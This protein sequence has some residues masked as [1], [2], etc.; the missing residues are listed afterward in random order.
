VLTATRGSG[1]VVLLL[2]GCHN[3]GLQEEGHIPCLCH[4]GNKRRLMPFHKP[5]HG[6]QGVHKGR[7]HCR[8]R[9]VLPDQHKG[10]YPRMEERGPLMEA[11]ANTGILCEHNP[12][13]APHLLESRYITGVLG[14][15]VI[16]H[17]DL[18]PCLSEG[19]C[20]DVLSETAIEEKDEWVYAAWRLNSHRMASSMSRGERS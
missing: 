8:T 2:L 14:E 4:A 1:W 7:C 10:P 20:H 5:L 19:I 9:Q 3:L 13:T 16:M 6:W 17:L 15:M 12:P 18:C 11:I